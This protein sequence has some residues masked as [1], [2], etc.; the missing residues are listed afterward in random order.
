MRIM[1]PQFVALVAT[2][3]LAGAFIYGLLNVVPTF[4][5]VPL[6]VHL[7]YRTQLM[8]HNSITMQS[9]MIASVIT[10]FWYAIVVRLSVPATVFA[11]ISGLLALTSL[12][13][14]RFGNVPINQL[15]RRWSSG[16]IPANWADI[17]RAWDHFN[18]LR[19]MAALGCFV[20]F[21][22]ATI[23]NRVGR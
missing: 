8:K 6:N 11:V 18:L 22:A 15:I 3:L 7:A 9:V 10:P 17:L 1:I 16:D 23:V 20:S 2:G 5:E 13:V 4:Y 19:S 12:L 14:T 21:I